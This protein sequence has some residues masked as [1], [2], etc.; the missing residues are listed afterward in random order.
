MT[1]QGATAWA[2]VD[3]NLDGWQAVIS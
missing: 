3:C 2:A 1:T